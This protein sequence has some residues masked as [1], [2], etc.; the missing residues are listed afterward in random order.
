VPLEIAPNEETIAY[1]RT[2]QEKM[3]H[4]LG[5][6]EDAAEGVDAG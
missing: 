6:G 3:G 5:L 1:L 4:L 2:K